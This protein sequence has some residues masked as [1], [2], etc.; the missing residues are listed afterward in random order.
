MGGEIIAVGT[1]EEV[2]ANPNSVTGKYLSGEKSIVPLNGHKR[3]TPKGE[4]TIK[5]AQLHNLKSVDATFPLGSLIGVTGVSGS[6][7]GFTQPKPGYENV[8]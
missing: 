1:P 3:R 2:I 8:H 6:G 7:K 5:G 4:L